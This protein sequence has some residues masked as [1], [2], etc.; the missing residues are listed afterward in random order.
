MGVND[1][2]NRTVKMLDSQAFEPFTKQSIR[3][4]IDDQYP[5]V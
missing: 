5:A 1:S 2:N 4:C 3:S